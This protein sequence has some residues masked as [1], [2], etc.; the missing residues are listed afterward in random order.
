MA[1]TEEF[2]SFLYEQINGIGDI[3]AKKMFGEYLI[4]INNKPILL[5][6]DNTVFIKIL[7]EI[8]N[9]MDRATT[10][11][12]YLGAKEHYILDVEDTALTFDV[13]NVLLEIIPFPKPRKKKAKKSE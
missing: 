2:I 6:C 1:T 13:I 7:P 12:P 4:Y 3:K 9:L 5:V 8:K 10:G 11:Y